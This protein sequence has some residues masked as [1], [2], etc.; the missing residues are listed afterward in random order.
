[1]LVA[2]LLRLDVMVIGRSI[3]GS[4]VVD[5][6]QGAR[7]Q[8]SSLARGCALFRIDRHSQLPI[9]DGQERH[10]KVVERSCWGGG[11]PLHFLSDGSGCLFRGDIGGAIGRHSQG[12]A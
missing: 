3:W 1:V 10:W 4:V 2:A 8:T 9:K 5:S 12:V 7:N 11:V 6:P